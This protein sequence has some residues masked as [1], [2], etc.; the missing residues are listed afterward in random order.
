[1]DLDAVRHVYAMMPLTEEVV[2]ALNP[3][4]TLQ[5]LKDDIAEIGYPRP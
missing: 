5:D 2:T 3:E 4:R 1:L